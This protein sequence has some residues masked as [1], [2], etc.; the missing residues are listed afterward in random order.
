M[1][2]FD[3]KCSRSHIFEAWFGS[4]EDY[5]GQKARGL[6]SCPLCGDRSVEKAAMAPAV[7]A[8]GNQR[9]EPERPV[10]TEAQS[11]AVAT[12][13][14][15]E[16][17]KLHAV[18]EKLAEVQSQLLENSSWVG[19]AFADK[20][21]A[22]HYGDEPMASIHGTA[23]MDEAQALVEEGIAVAPLPIPIVPPDERN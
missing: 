8:K 10:E 20:A 21:R 12:M 9:S 16:T 17:A 19:N 7:A 14:A 1:I 15:E 4:S 6:V 22:M 13:G 5:E 11:R 3:L 2:V 18:I 23:N